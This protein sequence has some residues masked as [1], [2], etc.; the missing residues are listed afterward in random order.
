M[1]KTF[2]VVGDRIWDSGL[3][4]VSPTRPIPFVSMPINYGRAYGGEDSDPDKPDV[5]DTYPH[6]P[7]GVGHYPLSPRKA[8]IGKP[9]P[10]TA[11]RR[12]IVDERKGK[13]R[14]MSFGAIGRNFAARY[15]LAGTYDKAWMDN[16]MPFW[17]DDFDYAYFQAAPIDQQISYPQGGEEV[18]LRN[19]TAEGLARFF[20]PTLQMEVRLIPHKGG[21]KSISGNID[22]VL[23]EPDERRMMLTWRV[24]WPLRRNCFELRRVIAY[25]TAKGN[26]DLPSSDFADDATQEAAG[27]R[28]GCCG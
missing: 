12:K 5:V 4:W 11:E 19:L 26:S 1:Q 13:Y 14:P 8:M 17:P 25:A 21:E 9:L 22:T 18:V 23:I 10:N 20:L 16:R 15:P 6:N 27:R 24:S 3:A 28:P 2:S 7:I